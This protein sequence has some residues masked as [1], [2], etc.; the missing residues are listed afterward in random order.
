MFDRTTVRG[1]LGDILAA[2][3]TIMKRSESIMSPD[4]FTASDEGRIKL[5]SICMLIIAIGESL[6]NIDKITGND[7]LNHYGDIDWKDAKGMRD[8][9]SHH[10]FDIDKEIV[11]DV[12]KNHIPRLIVVINKMIK[13]LS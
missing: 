9:V 7:F 6:K 8:V 1:I 13:D 12:C 2:S 10:Y 11:F 5:D 3:Q 4:D